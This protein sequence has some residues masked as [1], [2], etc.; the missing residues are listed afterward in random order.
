[1]QENFVSSFWWTLSLLKV[2]NILNNIHILL[3]KT[4][5]LQTQKVLLQ[6]FLK[7]NFDIRQ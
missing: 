1:M 3:K 5:W 4:V 6:Q 2:Y 7:K